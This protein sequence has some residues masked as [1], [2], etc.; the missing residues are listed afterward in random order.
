MYIKK[1]FRINR[2]NTFLIL[3]F[4]LL[5]TI[6][7]SV[8]PI[9][10]KKV[11][12]DYTTFTLSE[13]VGYSIAYILSVIFFLLFEYLKKIYIGKYHQKYA[14]SIKHDMFQSITLAPHYKINVKETSDYINSI[15]NDAETVF[16]NY[17]FCT[18]ELLISSLSFV[19]YFTY[20]IYMNIPLSIIVISACLIS[21]IIPKIVGKELQERRKEKSDAE[22]KL[23]AAIEGLIYGSE[24]FNYSSSPIF[25]DLFDK[26][27]EQHENSLF[28]LIKY[29]SFTHI[30]SGA[31][32]YF[33][34][35][36]AFIAGILMIYYNILSL[37][38]FIAIIAYIDLVSVPIRDIVFEI[39]T[40]KSSK[41]IREKVQSILDL[42]EP[43]KTSI[44]DFSK[45][46]VEYIDYCFDTFRLSG[47]D[48][49]INK[50]D[51]IIIIGENG[52]GKSTLVKLISGELPRSGQKIFVDGQAIETIDFSSLSF[53]ASKYAVYAGTME[54][55]LSLFGEYNISVNYNTDKLER[56]YLD[57][58]G[59]TLSTGQKAKLMISRGMNSGKQILI[60]DELFAHVDKKSEYEITEELLKT[61]RT[62]IIVSHNKSDDYVNLFD[63]TIE[64]L[65]GRIV[66]HNQS[67]F[68]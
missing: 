13:I 44:N 63:K 58:S 66:E 24:E 35:I 68:S 11:I 54:D 21:M 42:Y 57:F 10:T 22:A 51:K 56:E 48:I 38:S 60:L 50:G 46:S 47:S 9:L 37:S 41:K 15:T 49:T 18:I 29:Q 30:F 19:V 1:Y 61:N 43:V 32:L 6:F 27:N 28:S 25:T 4:T 53:Y 17:I 45:L 34:N 3:L 8:I 52:A 36:V 23:I 5:S 16:D 65:D 33:I 40:I 64:I 20:M 31:S 2:V 39:I 26:Y 12:D 67:R 62:I 14:L 7:I 55:N 59:T